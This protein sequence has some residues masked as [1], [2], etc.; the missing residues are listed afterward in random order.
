MPKCF[1]LF[2]AEKLMKKFSLYVLV[3]L[4]VPAVRHDV[5][6]SGC[7]MCSWVVVGAA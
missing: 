3:A 1:K 7:R 2:K 4:V 5:G 6:L